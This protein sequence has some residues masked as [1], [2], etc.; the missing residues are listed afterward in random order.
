MS[1]LP[2]PD[3]A[4]LA[5]VVVAARDEEELVGACLAA[6]AGQQGVRPEEYEVL[7]VLDDCR[8]ATEA[9]ALDAARVHPGLR[10]RLLAAA[11][12]GVGAAR[13]RG[14]EAACERLLGLGRPDGLIASTDADSRVAPDW[15]RAQLDAVAAGA[16]AIGGRVELAEDEAAGLPP[17]ALERRR[18]QAGRRHLR[19]MAEAR[20]D[21]GDRAEHWQFS[22]ASI[23]LTAE[24]Y[25]RVGGL[26]PRAGLEDEALERALVDAGVPIQRL[27]SVR[28][29]TSA[30]RRG[31][32]PRG[33]A[34]D[35]ELAEWLERRSFAASSFPLE[36]LLAL[37]R[38]TVGVIVPARDV[39]RTIGGLLA[40]IAPLAAAG[41]VDDVLVVDGASSDGTPEVAAAAGARVCQESELMPEHG[42]ARGKGDAMWRGLAASRCDLVVFLDADTEDFAPHY[43]TGLLG[44]LLV[45]ERIHLV[46]GAFRRPFRAGHVLLPD[47]GGRVTELVA[48][49]LLNLFAPRLAG[50]RQPLAGEI[51][52]R[53]TLLER[54]P[55][56]VGY[57]VEIAMLIDALRLAGLDGLAQVDLGSRQNRHQPLRD[58]GPMAYAVISAAL[59]RLLEEGA[60]DRFAPGPLVLWGDEDVEVRQVPLLERPPLASLGAAA[61]PG[62]AGGL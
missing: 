28:V 30:R 42:R 34:R 23:G 44:P 62:D 55:F 4:L 11:G 37:K 12:E 6:L 17:A 32:A 52:G 26:A 60:L 2:A 10:L 41:L 21:R 15:L 48:R 38:Q 47:E 29:E 58:L 5:S 7:L 22:G 16:R 46:K 14:M 53:R 31:R 51:A 27:L 45:E 59:G 40:S 19:V 25:R 9:R 36:R 56:P 20:A 13:R 1:A 24:A 18:L 8:D 49:P 57:G 3:P 50:F 39:A 61:A 43:L 35:L 33:L 54:L